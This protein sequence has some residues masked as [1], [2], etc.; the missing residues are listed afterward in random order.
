MH[1]MDS[2]L[3]AHS[4]SGVKEPFMERISCQFCSKRFSR[5]VE[6]YKHANHAHLPLILNDWIQCS[7]VIMS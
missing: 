3:Q 1:E 7:E 2:C 5:T 6:L 4:N